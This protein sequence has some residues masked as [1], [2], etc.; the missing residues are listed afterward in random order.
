MDRVLCDLACKTIEYNNKPQ[1]TS[2]RAVCSTRA[3]NRDS[4]I[5]YTCS[6]VRQY[7][8]QPATIASCSPRRPAYVTTCRGCASLSRVRA[9]QEF[10]RATLWRV[11]TNMYS[12]KTH[13][14]GEYAVRWA[15]TAS[16]RDHRAAPH[17][18]SSRRD[19]LQNGSLGGLM[20][21]QSLRAKPLRDAWCDAMLYKIEWSPAAR[22]LGVHVH[23]SHHQPDTPHTQTHSTLR[24]S[25][26]SIG[27]DCDGRRTCGRDGARRNWHLAWCRLITC[28][29]CTLLD[30]DMLLIPAIR[31]PHQHQ[32]RARGVC[33]FA[34]IIVGVDWMLSRLRDDRR[35]PIA[36]TLRIHKYISWRRTGVDWSC[37]VR[38]LLR[39]EVRIYIYIYILTVIVFFS[40]HTCV[41][42]RYVGMFACMWQHAELG[43]QHTQ[44]LNRCYPPRA[45][46]IV[47][48]ARCARDVK[49]QQRAE[50]KNLPEI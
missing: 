34:A 37:C 28:L 5:L 3:D 23:L 32:H 46:K 30:G 2:S 48:L 31:R 36:R 12:C 44:R 38:R 9:H 40:V 50:E 49:L 16:S 27:G 15:L 22:P 47:W 18:Q 6:L 33:E 10:T 14:H 24:S 17:K 42:I 7:I 29:S 8:G 19:V 35:A 20:R 11:Y 41:C 21:T 4:N 43:Q 1:Q 45:Q 26:R 39:W 13:Q 25:L